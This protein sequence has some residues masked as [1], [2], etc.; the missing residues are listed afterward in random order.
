M[1]LRPRSSSLRAYDRLADRLRLHRQAD[2]RPIVVVEGDSDR[3][4]L[5]DV[6]GDEAAVVF[7]GGTRTEVLAAAFEL[8]RMNVNRVVCI[9]DHDFDDVVQAAID[10]GLP[11]VAY[12]GADVED[13]LMASPAARRAIEE[14]ASDEKL[15]TYGLA[16]LLDTVREQ[17]VPMGRLRR[18]NAMNGWGLVFDRIDLRSKVD[19]RTLELNVLGLC[20]ALAGTAPSAVSVVELQS[21]AARGDSVGCPRTGRRRLR[22]RDQLAFVAVALRK[23]VGSCRKEQTDPEFLAAIL[24]SAANPEWMRSTEWYRCVSSVGDLS[25]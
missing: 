10:A 13:M 1:S 14:L 6:V 21:V 5:Q 4:L 3:R 15:A 25:I 19:K 11:V 12:D 20:M 8:E 16:S 2:S 7:V 23:L 22:G 24:R 18:G 17:A 9:V